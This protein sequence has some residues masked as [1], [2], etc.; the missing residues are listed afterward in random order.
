MGL[1]GSRK[2][3]ALGYSEAVEAFLLLQ[4][5]LDT[6]DANRPNLKPTSIR[7]FKELK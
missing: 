1:T 3:I 5:Y 2:E 4:A 7:K 6:S